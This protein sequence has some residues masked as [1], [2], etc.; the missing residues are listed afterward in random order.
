FRRV[1]FR[2]RPPR[3]GWPAD[4]PQ[5]SFTWPADHAWCIASDVDPAWFTVGGSRGLV[6]AVLAHPDLHAEPATHGSPPPSGDVSTG[7]D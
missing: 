1:L 3:P 6:D 5:A 7:P 2:S 4:L